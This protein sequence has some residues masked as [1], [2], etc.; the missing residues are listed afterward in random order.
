M[1][2][3][4]HFAVAPHIPIKERGRGRLAPS[5]IVPGRDDMPPA[6]FWDRM[7]LTPN[8]YYYCGG[9]VERL[10][11][12]GGIDVKAEGGVYTRSVW[13]WYLG[14]SGCIR[15]GRSYIG[16]PEDVFGLGGSVAATLALPHHSAVLD[17]IFDDVITHY[18]EVFDR[19]LLIFPLKSV[20]VDVLLRR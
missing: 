10:G 2:L 3:R 1:P 4:L 9:W 20:A 19:G 14:G 18:P 12:V 5:L 13:R 8:C 7:N 11:Y 6:R 15:M 16:R 17:G